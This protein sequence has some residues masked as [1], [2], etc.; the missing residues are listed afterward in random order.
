VIW[1]RTYLEI[2]RPQGEAVRRTVAVVCGL[3]IALCLTAAVIG[4]LVHFAETG[5]GDA[6]QLKRQID[7]DLPLGSSKTEVAMWLGAKGFKDSHDSKKPDG[8]GSALWVSATTNHWWE[9]SG[10]LYITFDFDEDDRLIESDARW[11]ELAL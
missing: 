5:E 10:E 6:K 3:V 7:A 9:W 1:S 11:H 2:I 4:V 8:H